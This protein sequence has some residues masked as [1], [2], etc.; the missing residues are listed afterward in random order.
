MT[1]RRSGYTLLELLVVIAAVVMLGGAVVPTLANISRDTGVKAGADML[2]TYMAEARARS[3]DEGRAYRLS[4]SSEGTAIRVAPA[5]QETAD[6][7]D[8][9]PLYREENLPAQ[10]TATP[11]QSAD[12]EAG[13]NDNGWISVAT[14]LADGTCRENSAALELSQPRCY[15]IRL[16]VRGLTGAATLTNVTATSN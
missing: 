7:V 13:M 16:T 12:G 8:T 1:R 6:P 2:R 15:S 14:F 11:V 5:S 3:I 4:V 9:P 10:V